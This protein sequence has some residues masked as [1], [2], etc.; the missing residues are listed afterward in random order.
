MRKLIIMQGLPGAGKSTLIAQWGVRDYT[1]SSDELRLLLSSPRL[2]VDGSLEIS[3][4]NGGRVWQLLLDILEQRMQIGATTFVD[5]THLTGSSLQPYRKLAQTYGYKVYLLTL[6]SIDFATCSLRNEARSSLRRVPAE[7]MQTF[8]EQLQKFEAPPWVE[9]IGP[10][11]LLER[12][13][14]SPTPMTA[15]LAQ[16]LRF[17]GDLHGFAA[18]LEAFLSDFKSETERVVFT[19]DLLGEGPDNAR[20]FAYALRLLERGEAYVCEGYMERQ[21]RQHLSGQTVRSEVF[22]ASVRPQLLAAEI[23][24]EEL[25]LFLSH[26]REII[27]LEG[28]GQSVFICHGGLAKPYDPS[29]LGWL[30]ADDLILGAG[31]V[32]TDLDAS[33]TQQARAG[34]ILIHGHRNPEKR[35]IDSL[36]QCFNLTRIDKEWRCVNWDLARQTWE[37]KAYRETQD[38]EIL[39]CRQGKTD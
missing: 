18:P 12:L 6:K 3:Q 16:R 17:I 5:A 24:R 9:E 34:Q 37:P 36:P 2:R 13:A 21:L 14:L 8:Y 29:Q 31:S 15:E 7:V 39:P 19:G 35:P 30:A 23:P 26:L 25:E 38:H 1:L 32:E 22:H 4:R 11:D 10:G 20:V 28:L 33:F 27:S